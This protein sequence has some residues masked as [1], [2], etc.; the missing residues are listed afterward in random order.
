MAHEAGRSYGL[1]IGQATKSLERYAAKTWDRCG[2]S[3]AAQRFAACFGR[4]ATTMLNGLPPGRPDLRFTAAVR[5]RREPGELRAVPRPSVAGDPLVLVPL[6]IMLG[7]L[8]A[9][10]GSE[11]TVCGPDRYAMLSHRR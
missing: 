5:S 11:T 6:K 7:M 8:P 9:D 10:V 1:P 2:D 3:I 4:V